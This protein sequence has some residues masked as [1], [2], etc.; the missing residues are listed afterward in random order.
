MRNIVALSLLVVAGLV[1]R[2]RGERDD[3]DQPRHQ[4]RRKNR[5]RAGVQRLG[6]HRQER[7][8]G[9]R[10]VRRAERHEEL[11]RQRL[12]PRR[13]DRQ[14]LL[15]LV[16]RQH[17]GGRDRIAERARGAGRVSRP[18]R[19]RCAT[20]S[21]RS[22]TAVPARRRARRTTTR[23]P[24]M[25]STP[26][27][28]TSTR[29]PR[30]PSSASTCTRTRWRKRRSSAFTWPVTLPRKLILSRRRS[31]PRKDEASAPPCSGA[32]HA[33]HALSLL[34]RR[35]RGGAEVLRSVRTRRDRAAA[36]LRGNADGRARRRGVARQGPPLGVR[37]PGPAPLRLRRARTRSR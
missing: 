22:A 18:A 32:C 8:A 33:I 21:A 31:G 13:A 28:S 35:L 34:P 3:P 9:A 30:P 11:R 20:T 6:L 26:T 19:C 27:S 10:L 16:G 17:S 29:T 5:R 15:A 12:R 37:R 25:R 36:A 23:S 14:R 4:A 2:K 1:E 7:L 24:S